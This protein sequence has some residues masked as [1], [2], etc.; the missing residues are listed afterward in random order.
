MRYPAT[1]AGA[2]VPAAAL[3]LIMAFASAPVT[4]LAQQQQ[5]L[6][7][8]IFRNQH[9]ITAADVDAAVDIIKISSRNPSEEDMRAIATKYGYDDL[10]LAYISTKFMAGMLLLIPA[11]LTADQ[12][13]EQFGTPLALPD[14]AEL[15]VVRA[16]LP[17]LMESTG[18][19]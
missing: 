2:A 14:D 15:E 13:A 7:D 19:K 6:P 5:M 3:A 12:V 9:P 11:G 1:A 17:R 16:A 8:E 4:A 10:R 18:L